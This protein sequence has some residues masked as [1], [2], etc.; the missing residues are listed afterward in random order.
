MKIKITYPK[1]YKDKLVSI[2]DISKNGNKVLKIKWRHW[3]DRYW[4]KNILRGLETAPITKSEYLNKIKELQ[5]LVKNY[6]DN[7]FIEKSL[8]EIEISLRYNYSFNTDK[9][10]HYL[11]SENNEKI[12]NFL[13]KIFEENWYFFCNNRV[14]DFNIFFRYYEEE[15][16]FKLEY[17]DEKLIEW[18]FVYMD[19]ELKKLIDNIKIIWWLE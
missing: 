16:Y 3:T 5:E 18:E 17:D 8:F 6:Y 2:K 9:R 4:I 19:E 1:N 14:D 11:I 13:H 15:N 12:Y 10:A 7:D